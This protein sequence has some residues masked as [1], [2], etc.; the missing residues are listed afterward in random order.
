MRGRNY[1]ITINENAL[2]F[3]DIEKVKEI[4]CQYAYILHDKDECDNLHYHLVIMFKNPRFVNSICKM[5]QGA[6][7]ELLKD[8]C[9]VLEY[10]IHRN[11]LE[12]FQ[13][14]SSEVISNFEIEK[15]INEEY[16]E[17]FNPNDIV[18]YYLEGCNSLIAFYMRFGKQ[19]N[20][21][22]GLI[23]DIILEMQIEPIEYIKGEKNE[24]K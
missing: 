5:F 23:K 18:N 11:N 24:R 6:H 17:Y 3:K 19:I 2:C 9:K 8:K 22:R 16:V 12:K 20:V 13:Y 4:D 7:V 1:F 15:V 21:F 14:D 10:L